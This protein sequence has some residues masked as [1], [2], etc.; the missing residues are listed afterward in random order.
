MKFTI[1]FVC[2]ALT[3]TSAFA[4]ESLSQ[5]VTESERSEHLASHPVNEVFFSFDSA[6]LPSPMADL[7]PIVAWAEQ[8]P[9][10]TIVLDGSADSIGPAPYN[11]RLS[12]R[13]AESVR[14]KLVAMGVDAD[15]IVLAL[16]GEDSL[17]RT[18]NALD[19][20]VT[21]WTTQDPLHAIVDHSL[22]RATAV[23]W[24][25]PVTYAELYPTRL[26]PEVAIR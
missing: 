7:T 19:R 2:A 24:G 1:P 6:R 3:G 21:I 15:R 23:L 22:V 4:Q 20:R 5:P 17:R 13:R 18:S 11:V 9:T 25:E 16:Y 10:G 14:S 8:H 12:A 26:P